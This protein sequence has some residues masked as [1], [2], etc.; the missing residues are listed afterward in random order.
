MLGILL[1]KGVVKKTSVTIEK[2][3]LT[4]DEEL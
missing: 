1:G 2:L 4:F 3:E